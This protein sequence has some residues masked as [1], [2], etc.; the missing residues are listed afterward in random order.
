[1]RPHPLTLVRAPDSSFAG[2]PCV[3][4]EHFFDWGSDMQASLLNLLA[5]RKRNG[6]RSDSK[7]EILCAEGD[8]YVATIDNK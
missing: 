6:I 7:L 3:F 5:I 2:I 8:M 1:M 4:W